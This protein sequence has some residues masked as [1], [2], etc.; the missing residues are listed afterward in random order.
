LVSSR[1]PSTV[2]RLTSVPHNRQMVYA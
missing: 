2:N 1:L